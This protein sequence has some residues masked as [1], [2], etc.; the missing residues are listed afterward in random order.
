MDE[1]WHRI[2][3]YVHE[4]RVR[5][6]EC[7]MQRVVFN[8]HY[9]AYCDDAIDT[10]FRAVLA[11]GESGGFEV[12]GFDFMLKTATL[13]W[14]A[15]LVFGETAQLACSI[16]RWGNA[17]F[18]VAVDGTVGGSPRFSATITYVNVSPED[19]RP[20]RIPTVVRERLS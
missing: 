10:W 3:T 9:M 16:V 17:S 12:L 8:A 13:T 2:V 6:G 14:H 19:Q 20:S 11:P 7:D 15:P 1:R 5:Y 18:D 4:V